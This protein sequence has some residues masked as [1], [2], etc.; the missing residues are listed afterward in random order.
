VLVGL[1]REAG[2][3]V[4]EPFGDDLDRRAVRDEKRCVGVAEVVKPDARQLGALD[5]A[6]E[7][8]AERLRVEEAAAGATASALPSV[9]PDLTRS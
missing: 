1:H 7:E 3:R 9:P 4:A 6:G 5:D 2:V 8:L